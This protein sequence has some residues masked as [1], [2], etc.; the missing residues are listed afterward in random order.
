MRYREMMI[1]LASQFASARQHPGT[2]GPVT[3][4]LWG[5]SS[6]CTRLP[7]RRARSPSELSGAGGGEGAPR[8]HHV[9]QQGEPAAGTAGRERRRRADRPG[10][11][12]E[13]PELLVGDAAGLGAQI[14]ALGPGQASGDPEIEAVVAPCAQKV[15]RP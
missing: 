13:A 6:G 8:V 7:R 9:D 12:L 4:F 1:V 10:V 5:L 2:P 15:G 3:P 11:I 14:E